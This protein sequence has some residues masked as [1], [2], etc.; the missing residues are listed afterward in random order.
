M[1]WP[2]L[3]S[4]PLEV[5]RHHLKNGY[6][7]VQ[8]RS[9]KPTALSPGQRA[10][11]GVFIKACNPARFLRR[12]VL[13]WGAAFAASRKVRLADGYAL[14]AQ[15]P[16]SQLIIDLCEQQ[17]TIY[18]DY[19]EHG[20]IALEKRGIDPVRY[21]SEISKTADDPLKH[22]PINYDEAAM[23]RL[24]RFGL[25]N[26]FIGP[27]CRHLGLL[28][29]LSGVRLLYSP[30]ADGPLK[31][32]QLVHRDPEGGKQVKLFMAVRRVAQENGPFTFLPARPSLRC[33]RTAGELFRGNRTADK[34]VSRHTAASEWV[35]HVGDP[36]D[37]LLIDTSRCFHYGSRPAPQP[38]FLL[39]YS[40]HDPLGSS[41]PIRL[42]A[43]KSARRWDFFKDRPHPFTD[44][45][46]SRRI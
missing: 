3:L 6:L 2:H 17:I 38:R 43:S 5:H 15:A 21:K 35:R 37:V 26:Q 45:L 31:A 36:G 12:F 13:G 11:L 42:K 8:N 46:L 34:H 20:D 1:T 44:H 33:M 41:Y 18:F 39:Y 7:L 40:F 19:L 22:V 10:T 23:G 32:A 25:Q 14:V 16:N 29:I 27:I 30:N 4:L 9:G 28:P 24:L